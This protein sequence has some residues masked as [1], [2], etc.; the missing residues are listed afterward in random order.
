ML[1]T[2]LVRALVAVTCLSAVSLATDS[3]NSYKLA[4]VDHPGQLSWSAEGFKIIESSAKPGGTELGIRGQDQSGV[5]TFLGF[6][7]LFPEKAPLTSAKC[8]DGVLGPEKKS[9]SSLKITGTDEISQS[10]GLP[11]SL[12]SYTSRGQ[13]G[14]TLYLVRGFVATRDICGDLKIYSYAPLNL[15][16]PDVKKLFSSFHLDERYSP[17]FADQFLYAQM[18]YKQ[19]MYGPAAPVFEKALAKVSE[20]HGQSAKTMQRVITDQAGMSYGMSGNI[21]RARAIFEKAVAADPD[22]PLYYYNLACADAEEHNLAGAKKHLQ[23]AFDRKANVIPGESMP[24]PA[25]DD[26][27]LP[28]RNNKDFWAFVEGLEGKQ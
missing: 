28:Y 25:K 2:N 6:L 8:L 20:D 13:G 7:F 12:V 19:H 4:L 14:K 5:Q 22:Y 3:D 1:R 11:V 26:S 9:N 15:Q 17:R 16:D 21:S 18:L 10:G 24:D 27:F 23:E